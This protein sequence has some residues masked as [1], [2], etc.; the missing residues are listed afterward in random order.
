M[1]PNKRSFEETTSL[2]NAF[3]AFLFKH[4]PESMAEIKEKDGRRIQPLTA[5][6]TKLTLCIADAFT[7]QLN[8][9]FPAIN[10]FKQELV[11]SASAVFGNSPIHV[12]AGSLWAAR[13][14]A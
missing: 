12:M 3:I 11:S 4:F 2:G 10:A 8:D 14:A 13:N 7:K 1:F 9:N 5:H 6:L